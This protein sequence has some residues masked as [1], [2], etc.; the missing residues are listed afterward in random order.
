MIAFMAFMSGQIVS[1]I[2]HYKVLLFVGSA[3]M[4][5]GAGLLY[6]LDIGSSGKYIGYQL[7]VGL[8]IGTAIQVP[9]MTIQA[10]SAPEDIPVATTIVLCALVSVSVF[11]SLTRC[12]V[13]QL[14]SG[15][16]GVSAAQSILTN[17]LMASLPKYTDGIDA[18]AVVA[19]GATSVRASFPPRQVHGILLS[20]MA[21]L[22]AAW[23]MGV[24]F[25]GLT[26]LLAF[27]T[28]W[29]SIKSTDKPGAMTAAAG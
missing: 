25:A 11:A 10:F 12:P 24:A 4:T 27:L 20:Y 1:R 18:G 22:K 7:L 9:V 23:A 13:F 8:G 19:A 16:F 28:P 15:A 29:R 26:F 21:G 2:G 14:V 17:R 3:C 5:I 6:T